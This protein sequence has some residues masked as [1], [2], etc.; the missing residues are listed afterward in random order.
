MPVIAVLN[1]KGGCGKTTISTNLAC[2]ILRRG[3]SVL[4][5]DTDSKQASARDWHAANEVNPLPLVALDR[6]NNFKSLESLIPSYDF[7]V[8]DGA[9]KLEDIIPA[10]IKAADFVLIPVQPSPY[11]IWAASDLVDIIK[12]RQSVTEGQPKA[13]FVISRAIE[14][15]TLSREIVTA[16]NEYG[17]AG[18]DTSINQRQV[19]A[20]TAAR[21]QSVFD[22]KNQE[23]MADIDAMTDEI[24]KYLNTQMR[25]PA[26]EQL[27]HQTA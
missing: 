8:I 25:K 2:A 11:D 5:V 21:G 1:S 27:K 12:A 19:Y 24:L 16:L 26:N 17:L 7:I 18:L 3:Y 10:A 20:Q 22:S 9:A 6:A 13:A 15:T 4:L 23:A 14:G